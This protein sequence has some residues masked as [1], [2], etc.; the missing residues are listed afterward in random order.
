[1]KLPADA[2]ETLIAA[3]S[4]LQSNASTSANELTE[5]CLFF[6]AG[7]SVKLKNIKPNYGFCN[8]G[9]LNSREKKIYEEA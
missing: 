8:C 1:M 2:N 3:L 4:M 7:L 9:K 6:N 5:D